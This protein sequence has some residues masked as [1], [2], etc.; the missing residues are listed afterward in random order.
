MSGT[1]YSLAYLRQQVADQF[2]S[3]EDMKKR[4]ISDL[5]DLANL[6]KSWESIFVRIV[7]LSIGGASFLQFV[8]NVL[9]PK[10]VAI[11]ILGAG[12]SYFVL[13]ISLRIY[14]TV[15]APRILRYI[16]KVKESYLTN[17][18]EPKSKKSLSELL[19]RVSAI[20][21][22]IFGEE[23][24][25]NLDE[26]TK[27]STGSAALHSSFFITGNAISPYSVPPSANPAQQA[28]STG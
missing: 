28:G 13:E 21:T 4:R 22:E 19:D 10:E 16:Q 1:V 17:Q 20:S 14:R 8:S 11:G 25:I 15:N 23:T 27:L 3:L 24:A 26:I 5:D 2:K 18:Y 7:G 9:G 12:I 6:S